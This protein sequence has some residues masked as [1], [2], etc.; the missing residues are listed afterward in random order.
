MRTHLLFLF[1]LGC[2]AAQPGAQTQVNVSNN[3]TNVDVTNVNVTQVSPSVNV[4]WGANGQEE[5]DFQ[6][7][8]L[9]RAMDEMQRLLGHAISLRFD[10]QMMPRP[11]ARFFDAFFDHE[12]GLIPQDL[13]RLRERDPEVFKFGQTR[14]TELRFDY[15]GSLRQPEV[16]FDV[17]AGV[18]LV[19]MNR[20]VPS[21]LMR[22]AFR[23]AFDAYYDARFDGVEAEQIQVQD[24]APFLRWLERRGFRGDRSRR[25]F[26]LRNATVLWTTTARAGGEYHD[27]VGEWL[28]DRIRFF[29]NDYNHHAD[30]L[31]ALP[32]DDPWHA[33]ERAYIAWLNEAWPSLDD[34]ARLK[35]LDAMYMRRSGPGREQDPYLREPFPGVDLFA[36]S[37]GVVDRWIAAG[38][39]TPQR[40]TSR[41]HTQKLFDFVVCAPRRSDRRRFD[42]PRCD[43][44]FYRYASTDPDLRGRLVAE[45]LQ[46]NDTALTEALFA[47]LRWISS[48]YVIVAW[49]AFEDVPE[50][51]A[52]ATIVLAELTGY[53]RQNLRT[54]LYDDA[55]RIWRQ[56]RASHGPL[57]YLLAAIGN[58]G[59][60]GRDMVPWDDFRRVFGSLASAADF[61]AYL[62][63][64]E[65][66][67]VQVADVWPALGD[68]VAGVNALTRPLGRAMSDDHIRGRHQGFPHR[69]LRDLIN[70]MKSAHQRAALRLLARFFKRRSER[71]PSEE[72][73]L[74][75]LIQMTER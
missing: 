11:V 26:A 19:K 72:R 9:R 58:R 57:L 5:I 70:N 4:A 30:E 37:L 29:T 3:V 75:S 44:D 27:A 38:R 47:N 36:L 24:Q 48:P 20:G 14:L 40:V 69:M 74:G 7:A 62:S 67:L 16:S 13:A 22:Y 17:D 6:D 56:S 50:Q 73:A 60:G 68:P 15:D 64:G 45:I 59:R 2:G 52:A 71:F 8:R 12:V 1:V 31:A 42:S 63:L 54:E 34:Q 23:E 10:V 51:W 46:R 65:D 41:D 25:G 53:S 35:L 49:R 61:E 55:A 32:D 33:G 28:V 43:H 66:A 21:G 39:P 18:L